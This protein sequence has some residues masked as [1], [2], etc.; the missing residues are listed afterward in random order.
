[1]V[2]YTDDMNVVRD[3]MGMPNITQKPE[4]SAKQ[5]LFRDIQI[6]SFL[7]KDAQ[8][9]L[10]THPQDENAL[11]FFD[12][13][14]QLLSTLTSEYERQFGPLNITGVNINDGWSWI[15]QPWPWEKEAW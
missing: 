6:V 8:L 5:Q 4:M 14:N 7:I 10:D 12:Y 9:F 15:E 1:M 11:S 13:Y 2:N 3:M